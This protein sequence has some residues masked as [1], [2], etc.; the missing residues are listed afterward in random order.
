MRAISVFLVVFLLAVAA[1][2]RRGGE[3][4]G[5][6]TGGPAPGGEAAA[7]FDAKVAEVDQY[8]KTHELK[9]TSREDMVAELGA[10]ERD[11]RA[12]GAGARGDGGLADRCTLAA[13]SMALYVQSLD[14]PPENPE[15]MSLALDAQ[16]KW[17]QA[18]GPASAPPPR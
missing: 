1:G 13:D 15:A 12:L 2:C 18:K 17:E 3:K 14:T 9:N 10:F 8:M 6:A 5:P 4:P 7:A 16:A 11:F